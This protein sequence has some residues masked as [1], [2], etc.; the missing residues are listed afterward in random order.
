[1]RVGLLG[2]SF[3]PPHN[4][5]VEMARAAKEA[6]SL[7]EVWLV[8]A[9]RPPHKEAGELGDFEHRFEMARLAAKELPYMKASDIEKK[10]PGVSYT[11][12]T[13]EVI[14]QDYPDAQLYFIMGADTV[15][16][17]VTWKN[18]DSIL[19]LAV[20]VVIPRNG[21]SPQDVNGLKYIL[22]E[23]QLDVLR[24]AYIEVEPVDISSTVI[25]ENARSK[26]PFEQ[27]VP[28]SVAEYILHNKLYL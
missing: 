10:L 20:P 3:N 12:R 24:A 11:Y 15:P 2:G 1:M 8:V 17:L 16:E 26:K 18:P 14:T 28:S 5:H 7:D 9:A 21:F 25:R 4:G 27:Y 13:L 19:N 23:S 6:H 22:P